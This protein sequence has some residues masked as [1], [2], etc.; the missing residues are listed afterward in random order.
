MSLWFGM[1]DGPVTPTRASKRPV[2]ADGAVPAPRTAVTL[3]HPNTLART[4][5][6]SA[7]AYSPSGRRRVASPAL[8]SIIPA[9]DR[10]TFVM[11][12][13]DRRG[14]RSVTPPARYERERSVTPRKPTV[15]P[16]GT[17]DMPPADVPRARSQKRRVETH[18]AGQS[19]GESDYR[20]K[21]SRTPPTYVKNREAHEG[22][23]VLY[24]TLPSQGGQVQY[25][26]MVDASHCG[27]SSAR[28]EKDLI[29]ARVQ[30]DK[31]CEMARVQRRLERVQ[32]DVKLADRPAP[33]ATG[34]RA[35]SPTSS[36]VSARD[37]KPYATELPVKYDNVGRS[38][39]R[40]RWR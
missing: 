4:N 11:C 38:A 33:H 39:V 35:A 27:K 29:A 37:Y 9:E 34:K 2:P 31:A 16:Y 32:R 30:T 3:M 22:F 17:S 8:T 12:P 36:R 6:E 18:L 40:S 14:R 25:M 28:S 23:C 21:R 13:G 19:Q 1:A 20:P 10:N 26:S 7:T 5:A 24:P 15:T